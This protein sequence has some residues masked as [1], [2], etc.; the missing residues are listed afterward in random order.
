MDMLVKLLKRTL[1]GAIYLIASPLIAFGFLLFLTYGLLVFLAVSL[2]S[3]YL[4]FSGRGV[5][6]PFPE[7]L[8]AHK[9]YQFIMKQTPNTHKADNG[10]PPIASTP[11][12]IK[13]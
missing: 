6:T 10:V 7:D 13:S 11:N 1:F 5:F 3:I 8:V 12:G 9:R 4:F 2:K